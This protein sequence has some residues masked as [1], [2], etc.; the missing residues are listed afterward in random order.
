MRSS[1][2]VY[3]CAIA[4]MLSSCG[5]K[6]IKPAEQ[7]LQQS[8]VQPGT[9]SNIPQPIKDSVVLPPPKPAGKVATYSVVVTNVPA[10]EI[11]F[12]LARDAKINLDIQ[13]GIQGT[14]RSSRLSAGGPRVGR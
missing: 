12:A 11:L 2:I 13:S 10:Q 8:D 4:V 14:V 3:L 1:N 7:H 9:V 5:T 6:P